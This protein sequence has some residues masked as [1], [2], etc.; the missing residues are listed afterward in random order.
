MWERL[1]DVVARVLEKVAEAEAPAQFHQ[2]GNTR[3]TGSGRPKAT[4]SCPDHMA[5]ALPLDRRME[6]ISARIRL[7]RGARTGRGGASRPGRHARQGGEASGVHVVTS[8]KSFGVT[9]PFVTS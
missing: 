8:T 9:S 2:G 1:D 4:K 7:W 6:A 5:E 3:Q